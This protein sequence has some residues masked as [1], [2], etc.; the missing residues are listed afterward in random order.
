MAT[1][2]RDIGTAA[3]IVFRSTFSN[4]RRTRRYS[5]DAE[6]LIARHLATFIKMLIH[7]SKTIKSYVY[8]DPNGPLRS[9]VIQAA[10]VALSH[11]RI[12]SQQWLPVTSEDPIPPHMDTHDDA[13]R[14]TRIRFDTYW[15]IASR[16]FMRLFGPDEE[17]VRT[18]YS[19]VMTHAWL[20]RDVLNDKTSGELG[21]IRRV[22]ISEVVTSPSDVMYAYVPINTLSLGTRQ[23][24]DRKLKKERM[25]DMNPVNNAFGFVSNSNSNGN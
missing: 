16:P 18:A 6:D 10:V 23:E 11:E 21:P 5:P 15:T 19:N 24:I 22:R 20:F 7:T 9:P 1:L 13:D 17:A 2:D 12:E 14:D 4:E 25:V 8:N 3:A